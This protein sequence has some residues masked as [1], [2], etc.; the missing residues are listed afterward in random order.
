MQTPWKLRGNHLVKDLVGLTKRQLYI[1]G[2]MFFL[3][4]KVDRQEV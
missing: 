1:H 4:D 3:D 2:R